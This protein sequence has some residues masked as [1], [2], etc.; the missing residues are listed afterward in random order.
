MKNYIAGITQPQL[1]QTPA[2]PVDEGTHG[3]AQIGPMCRRVYFDLGGV[4]DLMD[5]THFDILKNEIQAGNVVGAKILTPREMGFSDK[6]V[7]VDLACAT[8]DGSSSVTWIKRWISITVRVMT[9]TGRMFTLN[10][11]R[12]GI[13]KR[14][15]PLLILGKKTC[16][17]C[18]YKTIRQQDADRHDDDD[19]RDDERA[20]HAKK[21]AATH[22]QHH[23]RWNQ[24]EQRP[25]QPERDR[26]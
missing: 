22:P 13:V 17:L 11:L 6:G 7:P 14:T 26:R 2:R 18:G 19:N 8:D 12:I 1:A 5:D 15:T 24:S 3:Y 4:Y 21:W 10:N 23:T 25:V 20:R 9:D 16:S